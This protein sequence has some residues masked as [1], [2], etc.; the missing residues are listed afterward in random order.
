MHAAIEGVGLERGE[1]GDKRECGKLVGETFLV[2]GVKHWVHL[3]ALQILFVI[4][5]RNLESVKHC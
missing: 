5:F 2:R 4:N 3:T 1:P